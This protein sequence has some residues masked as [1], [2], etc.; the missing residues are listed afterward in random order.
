MAESA[1]FIIFLQDLNFRKVGLWELINGEV[2]HSIKVEIKTS[3]YLWVAETK[4]SKLIPLYVGKAGTSLK[5][6]MNEHVKGFKERNSGKRK[7]DVLQT[8]LEEKVKVD[9]FA[10]ESLIFDSKKITDLDLLFPNCKFIT[11]TILSTE[12]LEERI[13]IE[14]IKTNF[15]NKK[16]LPFNHMSDKT[17]NEIET[18]YQDYTIN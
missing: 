12:A 11:P 13:L 9:I 14:L 2:H 5:K 10:R 3:V 1:E 4:D 16:L 15:V 17:K 18:N 8:L 6:R 7:R